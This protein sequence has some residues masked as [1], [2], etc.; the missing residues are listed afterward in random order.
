MLT[1]TIT[2]NS[3]MCLL[4]LTALSRLTEELKTQSQKTPRFHSG[5]FK[6]AAPSHWRT[7]KKFKTVAPV[8][9]QNFDVSMGS[10]EAEGT[11]RGERQRVAKRRAEKIC[12]LKID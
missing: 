7:K 1:F 6:L 10:G 2:S 12:I 3:S 9:N 11:R 4:H 8:W 5:R